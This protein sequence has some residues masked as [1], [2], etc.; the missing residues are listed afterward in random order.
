MQYTSYGTSRVDNYTGLLMTENSRWMQS[1]FLSME[2][3]HPRSFGCV[4]RT[5]SGNVFMDRLM[6][7]RSQETL[8]MLPYPIYF[9][10]S[11]PFCSECNPLSSTYL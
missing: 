2:M 1:R 7:N 9:Y 3:K 5:T 10:S 6:M 4:G 11:V 8:V